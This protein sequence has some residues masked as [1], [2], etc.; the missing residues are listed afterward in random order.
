MTYSKQSANFTTQRRRRRDCDVT[1]PNATA[2]KHINAY[3][4]K[5]SSDK[6]TAN[7]LTV[8]ARYFTS[9]ATQWADHGTVPS[10][11]L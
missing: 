6:L 11:C 9:N 7:H 4:H 1:K 3:N 10:P 8:I 2:T 5:A